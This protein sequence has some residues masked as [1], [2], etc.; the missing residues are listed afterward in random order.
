MGKQT[1]GECQARKSL[2]RLEPLEP[3]AANLTKC[4]YQYITVL[5]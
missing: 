3:S 5:Q 1:P 2:E 4:I